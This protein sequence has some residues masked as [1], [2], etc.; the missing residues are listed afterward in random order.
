MFK[1][2]DDL[3]LRYAIKKVAKHM[4]LEYGIT[5]FE[6]SHISDMDAIQ[7]AISQDVRFRLSAQLEHVFAGI[8][9]DNLVQRSKSGVFPPV[10]AECVG[11]TSALDDEQ[12]A[13]E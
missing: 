13:G 5:K 3:L 10:P 9:A 4:T 12:K 11:K 1:K 6:Q 8:K 2:L 7:Y